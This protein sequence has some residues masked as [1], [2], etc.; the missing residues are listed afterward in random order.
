MI[1]SPAPAGMVPYEQP[2]PQRSD[3]FPRTRGD[4]PQPQAVRVAYIMVPPHPRGWSPPSGSTSLHGPGSPAPAGMVPERK[5]EVVRPHRFPR[6]RGDGPSRKAIHG[7]QL[8]VPPHPRGWSPGLR[9]D[10][11]AAHGSPAPAGMVPGL[12]RMPTSR[13][14][15]P[16]TRGDGPS[17]AC[18]A[19]SSSRVPPHPRGWSQL[20]DLLDNV[21]DGSPA[22]AGMVPP[23]DGRAHGPLRFPRTRGD[24]PWPAT[25]SPPRRAVPPHPRGWSRQRA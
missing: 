18:R 9:C 21:R 13:A 20:I 17:T 14:R 12:P 23:R 4:G 15:F 11:R 6:T 7:S 1:G 8:R 22:P 16:R 3:R 10:R 2:S 25:N 5:V 19:T 24:G